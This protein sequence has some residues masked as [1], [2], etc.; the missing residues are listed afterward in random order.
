MQ[1]KQSE[2]LLK[3]SEIMAIEL[4]N[5]PIIYLVINRKILQIIPV[6]LLNQHSSYFRIFCFLIVFYKGFNKNSAMISSF[7]LNMYIYRLNC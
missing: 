3:A 7:N 2:R 6:M 4:E 1:L 5:V